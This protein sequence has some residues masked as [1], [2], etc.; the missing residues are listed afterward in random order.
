MPLTS[1]VFCILGLTIQSVIMSSMVLRLKSLTS[2]W[3]WGVSRCKDT[4]YGAHPARV[5]AKAAKVSGMILKAFSTRDPAVLWPAFRAYVLPVLSYASQVW[6]PSNRSHI[7]LLESVQRKF[8]KRLNG[9]RDM[10]YRERLDATAPPHERARQA[11]DRRNQP[12]F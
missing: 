2:L 1:V 12:V 3:T 6:N 7:N 8:C 9:F 10:S 5:A 4:T 11:R